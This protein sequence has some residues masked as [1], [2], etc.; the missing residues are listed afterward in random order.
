LTSSSHATRSA[1][2]T[3]ETGRRAIGI[4]AFEYPLS[5]R[6]KLTRVR[7]LGAD[8]CELAVPGDVTVENAAAVAEELG[9]SG[10]RVSAVASL[11]KPNSPDGTELGLQLLEQ[12]VR[13]A[14]A[15]GAPYAVAYFGGHPSRSADEA[16]ERYRVLVRPM[17][18]LAGELGVTILIE[19]HFSHAPGDVTSGPDGCADLIA[20]V[21]SESFALNFDPCNFAIAG[22]DVPAAYA[23]LKAVIRNVHVKDAR[24]YDSVADAHYPGRVVEDLQ[25]GKFIFVPVGEGITDNTSVVEALIRDGYA[26]PVTVEAHT[27]AET[28]DEVFARGLTYCREAGL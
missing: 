26:G 4:A 7:E 20:A 21:D 5:L 16:I 24:P 1:T 13:S 17:I 23:K 8:C 12:S 10:V 19:N 9:E 14:Q 11:S 2:R 3:A 22:V 25:R 6:E 28:L 15:I 18:E 27:P